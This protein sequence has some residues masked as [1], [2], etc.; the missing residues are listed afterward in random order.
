MD[1]TIFYVVVLLDDRKRVSHRPDDGTEFEIV[2]D[3]STLIIVQ[4]DIETGE[5][6]V[7]SMYAPGRWGEV[8]LTANLPDDIE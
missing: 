4:R 3:A 7:V 6:E 5:A 1:D 8:D 2:V